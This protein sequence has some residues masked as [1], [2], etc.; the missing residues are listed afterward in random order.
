MIRLDQYL[1]NSKKADTRNKA[2]NMIKDALVSVDGVIILKSSLKIDEEKALVKVQEHKNYVSRAAFKLSAFLDELDL[3][4]EGA[5]ALDIGSSTGGFTQVL[6]EKGA[7]HVSCVDVGTDQLHQTLRENVRVSV[8]EN[9]DIREFETREKFDFVT[10]DV[11]FI[12]LLHILDDVDRLAHDKII[13]LFKPQFEVGREA[14][15]D[16]HGVVVDEKAIQKAMIHF[17]DA[18]S[19]KGWDLVLKSPSKLTG[20]EGNLEYCY[21]YRK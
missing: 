5:N 14:K 20:K 6:L 2:Q 16:K 15:R 10:S 11:S 12:S 7:L 3:D 21:F 9:Q 19:I 1:V 8:Y 18:C 17:E 4:I 13:L